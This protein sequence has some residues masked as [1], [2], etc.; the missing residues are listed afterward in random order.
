[1]SESEALSLH[2]SLTS[3]TK[4]RA[5]CGPGL[6]LLS[7]AWKFQKILSKPRFIN[8]CCFTSFSECLQGRSRPVRV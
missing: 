8:A 2:S 4:F 3:A 1:M 7:M 5:K 6:P